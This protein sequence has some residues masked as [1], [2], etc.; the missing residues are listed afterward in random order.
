MIPVGRRMVAMSGLWFV[1][2]AVC[3]FMYGPL[4]FAQTPQ[5]A[6]DVEVVREHLLFT[7]GPGGV[8]VLHLV[9]LVNVGP[10]VAIAVPLTVPEGV[11]WAVV[12]EELIVEQDRV[13]DPR[14]LAVGEGRRYTLEYEIPWQ[15]LPMPIRRPVLYPTGELLLWAQAGELEL[16]GVNL[17]FSGR[18]QLEGVELDMYFMAGVQPHPAW[19]VVLDSS[20]SRADRLPVLTPA[21]QRSDPMDILRT[22][23]LPRLLLGAL[24]VMGAVGLARRLFPGRPSAGKANGSSGAAG[25][26]SSGA[27]GGASGGA[28]LSPGGASGSLQPS[29]GASGADRSRGAGA[30]DI[31]P[32]LGVHDEIAR[33]KEEIVRVDVAYHSGELDDDVYKERREQMKRR[34]LE[35][36]SADKKRGAPGGKRP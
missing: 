1:M 16:R 17:Q 31:R 21:G 2:A 9:D 29:S 3:V 30:R 20:H 14:P 34:L 28:G 12:P 32:G 22:H 26:S 10:R 7:R 18:Q 13:V 6:P 8:Q 35:L 19:Q 15:R 24:L 4:S 11:Q 36:M 23:P 27:S 5:E 25:G 33:L